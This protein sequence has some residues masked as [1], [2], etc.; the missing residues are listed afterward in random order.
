[1]ITNDDRHISYFAMRARLRG[2]MASYMVHFVLQSCRWCDMPCTILDRNDFGVCNAC[3]DMK[4][5]YK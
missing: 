2:F 5:G 1:M 3:L 4:Y